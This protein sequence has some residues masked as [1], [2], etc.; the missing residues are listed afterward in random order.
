MSITKA[1][2]RSAV[3]VDV[4]KVVCLFDEKERDVT[5]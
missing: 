5:M 1:L 4:L 2:E 3:V